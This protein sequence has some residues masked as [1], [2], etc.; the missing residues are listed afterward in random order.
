MKSTDLI[1]AK[2]VNEEGISDENEREIRCYE[3]DYL[4]AYPL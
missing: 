4:S 2:A 3:R 1:K